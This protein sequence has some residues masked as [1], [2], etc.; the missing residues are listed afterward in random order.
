MN[1]RYLPC[2]EKEIFAIG[3]ENSIADCKEKLKICKNKYSFM[4]KYNKQ[5]YNYIVFNPENL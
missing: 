1:K 4:R 5:N 2:L 3:Q